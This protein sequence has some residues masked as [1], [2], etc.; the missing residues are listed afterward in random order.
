MCF[1]I[2]QR[3]QPKR[4]FHDRWVVNIG[5]FQRDSGQ[6]NEQQRH[7]NEKLIS[8]LHGEV[9]SIQTNLKILFF[10]PR[11]NGFESLSLG[12]KLSYLLSVNMTYRVLLL[13]GVDI[14]CR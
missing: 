5:F 9:E 7:L 12:L 13:Q 14:Y 6:T 8:E 3:W 10:A 11:R 2:L 1:F 4:R